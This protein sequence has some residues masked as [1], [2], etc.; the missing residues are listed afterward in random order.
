[1]RRQSLDLRCPALD[2]LRR[3]HVQLSDRQAA[4]GRGLQLLQVAGSLW[5]AGSGNDGVVLGQQ[6]ADQLRQGSTEGRRR[7]AAVPAAAGG[8]AAHVCEEVTKRVGV[9]R[10]CLNPLAH[11]C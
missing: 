1:M 4:T 2:G 5:L 3:S 10:K 8:L 7:I 9:I 6:L 11:K